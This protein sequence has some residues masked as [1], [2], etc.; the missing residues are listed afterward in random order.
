VKFLKSAMVL[1][2]VCALQ[3]CGTAANRYAAS[4]ISPEMMASTDKAVVLMSTGAPKSCISTATMIL[5]R[6]GGTNQSVDPVISIGVDTYVH[7]SEFPDHH[8]L[9]SAFSIAPG[10]YY[11]VP[12]ILNPMVKASRT[13]T[14]TF[15]AKAGEASYIG[16]LFM[17][18][19]CSL[20]A[21]FD[22]RDEY[23]R[24]LKEALAMNK[25][26]GNRTFV[27]RLM[28]VGEPITVK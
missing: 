11:F 25:A 15:E 12:M 16:E 24:D 6:H 8:G 1:L 4:T 7:T 26:I 20:S 27:K 21:Q 23:E 14:F 3:A 17:P 18:Q 9:I 5:A 19:S 10:K 13:P 22:V 2:S 28:Q